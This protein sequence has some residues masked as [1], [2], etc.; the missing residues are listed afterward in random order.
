MKSMKNKLWKLKLWLLVFTVGLAGGW[1]TSSRYGAV[2][3]AAAAAISTENQA[4]T[5]NAGLQ[6]QRSG[7]IHGLAAEFSV[8]PSI[9]EIV[10]RYSRKYLRAGGSEWRLLRTP[11]FLTYLMLSV[12]WVESKGDPGA[13]GDQGRA[14]GLTQIWTT[15]AQDYGRVSAQ[16]L[17]DPEINLSYSF[18]H[19][20]TL[21]KKY[22]GNIAMTLY[23]WNRGAGTIDKLVAYG[24]RPE[25]D[26]G[27]KVYGAALANQFQMGN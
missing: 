20:H 5:Q 4:Q 6:E 22:D 19:F 27:R 18:Q 21:L 24:K 10:D 7:Y 25:N 9:V 11:E 3:T 15:T 1:I 8:D 26:Y 12:I 16:Q 14:R 23:A 2:T 13:I 17:L